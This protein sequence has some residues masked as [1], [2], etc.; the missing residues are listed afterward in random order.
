MISCYFLS[1]MPKVAKS[2]IAGLYYVFFRF[3]RIPAQARGRA[4]RYYEN[5]MRFHTAP[6][7]CA[8]ILSSCLSRF[9]HKT[10][11]CNM[12]LPFYADIISMTK[13]V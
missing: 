8:A 12:L 2:K 6:I 13:A 10:S 3:G 1:L 7:P 4:I 11:K 5:A 9:A